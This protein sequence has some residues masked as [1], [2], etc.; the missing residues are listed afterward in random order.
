MVKITI[1][2]LKQLCRDNKIKGFSKLK[3]AQLI[4]LLNNNGVN[5]PE[6]A[7]KEKKPRA[8]RAKKGEPKAPKAP[9]AP[10]T[11]RAKKGEIKLPNQLN[12][13]AMTDRLAKIDEEMNNILSRENNFYNLVTKNYKDDQARID[14]LMNKYYSE[15]HRVTEKQKLQNLQAEKDSLLNMGMG[16]KRGRGFYVN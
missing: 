1:A 11:P 5:I 6:P 4:E 8:P 10:K 7:P 9:K 13:Q 16:K 14:K 3:K 12:K 2:N 15:P